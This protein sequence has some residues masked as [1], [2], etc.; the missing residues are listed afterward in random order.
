MGG[1]PKVGLVEN[2]AKFRELA[3][4]ILDSHPSTGDFKMAFLHIDP[5]VSPPKI[6]DEVY[7]YDR[8]DY[9]RMSVDLPG[10]LEECIRLKFVANWQYLLCDWS[11][12]SARDQA[13]LYADLKQTFEDFAVLF[14]ED[15]FAGY[16][17]LL[18][19]RYVAR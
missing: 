10:Y 6:P 18:E 1:L 15:D 2:M 16:K 3:S 4:Y 14:P 11:S 13:Y 7:F 8:G 9:F 19:T 12:I 5:A 17:E